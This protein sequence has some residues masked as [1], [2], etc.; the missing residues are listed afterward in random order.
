MRILIVDDDPA[1]GDY[2]KKLVQEMGCSPMVAETGHK[3]KVLFETE[4]ADMVLLD[5][6][7]PDMPGQSLIP[8]FRE[9]SPDADVVTMTGY[10][11][12]TLEK[13]AR[14]MGVTY[15]LVKPHEFQNLTLL[16][17]H[18]KTRKTYVGGTHD[19]RNNTG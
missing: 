8:K 11:S 13:E 2:L 1:V 6:V 16:I 4:P 19:R 5:L 15:Y 9:I 10:N 7:L 18:M 12:E 17:E 14:R 3:A